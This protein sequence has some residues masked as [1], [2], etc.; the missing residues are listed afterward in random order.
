MAQLNIRNV[1]P[2]VATAF[3]VLCAQGGMTA[4]ELLARMVQEW[5]RGKA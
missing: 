2:E 3:R 5:E 4:A 1:P